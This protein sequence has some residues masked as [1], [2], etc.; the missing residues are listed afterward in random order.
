MN[1]SGPLP[2]SPEIFELT[3]QVRDILPD[4]IVCM[5]HARNLVS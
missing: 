2:P 5:V 1:A 4:L 3:P